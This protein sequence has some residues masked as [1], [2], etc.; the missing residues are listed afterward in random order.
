MATVDW[1]KNFNFINISEPKVQ[2]A[3]QN[4]PIDDWITFL[5]AL[6]KVEGED[7][8]NADNGK[9]YIGIY[10]FSSFTNKYAVFNDLDFSNNIGGML[11]TTTDAAY[12][13]NPIA[14]ELSAIM[15]FSGIP[16]ITKSFLSKYSY[17]RNAAPWAGL[18]RSQF[19]SM[20]GG[21]F[22]IQ[23]KNGSQNVGEV[24][25]ITLTKAAISAAAHLVGQGG[26]ALAMYEIYDQ[27]HDDE[28]NL[29]TPLPTVALDINGGYVGTTYVSFADGNGIAFSTYV[30]LFQ[31]FDVSPLTDAADGLNW[32]DFN[33]F[34][35]Q[36]IAY[37]KD[38]IIADMVSKK[39]ETAMSVSWGGTNYRETVRA[40][41]VGLDL[42]T[43]DLNVVYGQVVLVGAANTKY[44]DSSDLIYGLG[45]VDHVLTGGKG[46]DTLY[47]G[48]GD[49]LLSGGEGN[50][51]MHDDEGN[52][53]FFGGQGNDTMYGGAGNDIYFIAYGDGNDTIEDK[54][55]NN[56]VILCG[57]EL[58][59]FYD[60]GDH[61][62][63]ISAEGGRTLT[64]STGEVEDASSGIVVTL[65][66][67]FAEG[68]FG[69]TLVTLPANPDINNTIYGTDQGWQDDPP[70]EIYDTAAN[71]K[72]FALGGDDYVLCDAG[73]A[74]WILGGDG[75]DL[76]DGELSS[77]CIIEGGS[78]S[79]IIFG[80]VNGNNQLFGDIYGEMDDLIADGETA[81]DNGLRGD[82]VTADGENNN[83]LFG[84]LRLPGPHFSLFHDTEATVAIQ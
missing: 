73:G 37:R 74:N 23:W 54:D 4:R 82:I 38:K 84:L 9:G 48:G 59:F 45:D 8:Y 30:Q 36:M 61:E 57:K 19:D 17:T 68:D 56:T 35:Q 43:E 26:V 70:D 65:N 46:N 79:D 64:K 60:T 63:Y 10:Q 47:G 21:T 11:R 52:D 15:E 27:T 71:D 49:D 66:Q 51:V 7:K 29:I 58:K 31:S 69:I 14:Q 50:D 39:Q 44:T 13:A 41:L 12:K 72:I 25:T 62:T 77:S 22:K 5:D 53:V 18:S 2:A 24:Q 78:G 75:Y 3:H 80:G 16:D 83:F 32:T 40:I 67:N 33:Q 1:E 55:G 76:I 81:I 28:G 34:V 42:S 6:G 20:I